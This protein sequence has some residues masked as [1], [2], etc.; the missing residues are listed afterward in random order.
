MDYR[1]ELTV[2]ALFLALLLIGNGS[3]GGTRNG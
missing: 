2:A 1:A 3:G